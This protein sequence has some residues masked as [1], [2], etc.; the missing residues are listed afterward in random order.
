MLRLFTVLP[1]AWL[2]LSPGAG[3]A[4]TG[5]QVDHER[6]RLV[7]VPTVDGGEL[8]GRFERYEATVDFDP[9]DLATSRLVVDV[10]LGSAASGDA[11]RDDALKGPDFFAVAR[12][13]HALFEAT[14]FRATGPG[15]FEAQGKLR[16]RDVKREIRVPFEFAATAGATARLKGSTRMRRLDFGVGQ[17]DWKGTEWI[18]DEVRVEFDL[19]LRRTP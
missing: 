2:A 10:D 11:E 5:W 12:W 15:R 6:S 8:T 14:R 3:H 13:P 19:S 4:A 18:A 9:A 16:L 7:F 1:A 17:G